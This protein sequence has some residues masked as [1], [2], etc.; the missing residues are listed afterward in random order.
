[1]YLIYA[2]NKNRLAFELIIFRFPLK[3]RK[4]IVLKFVEFSSKNILRQVQKISLKLFL[5]ACFKAN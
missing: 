5:C 1:M 3:S 2:F 4:S